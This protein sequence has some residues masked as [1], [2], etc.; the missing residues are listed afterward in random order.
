[1][2]KVQYVAPEIQIVECT[3]VIMMS[4]ADVFKADKPTWD[5]W[6]ETL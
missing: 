6:S 2:E 5:I 3:D 1:M 4:G